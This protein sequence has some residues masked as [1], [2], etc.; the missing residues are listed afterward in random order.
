[1]VTSST[2]SDTLKTALE[3]R[4]FQNLTGIEEMRSW[5]YGA[6]VF[7]YLGTAFGRV[8]A[9]SDSA[10]PRLFESSDDISRAWAAPE[11]L[12]F[13]LQNVTYENHAFTSVN[14]GLTRRC[15]LT[16]GGSEFI[17]EQVIGV[18]SQEQSDL[19]AFAKAITALLDD[20]DFDTYRN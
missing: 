12:N 20:E 17:G 6:D 4:D 7:T 8:K 16:V 1:M 13:L 18:S 15:T 9:I 14:L 2:A 10:K 5:W 19:E 3:N 11:L